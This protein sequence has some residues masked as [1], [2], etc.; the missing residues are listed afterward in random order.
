MIGCKT[1]K[2]KTQENETKTAKI[3]GGTLESNTDKYILLGLILLLIIDC[4]GNLSY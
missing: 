1:W 2:Q 4:F 3:T